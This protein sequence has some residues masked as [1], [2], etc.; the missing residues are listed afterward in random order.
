[1]ISHDYTRNKNVYSDFWS[2]RWRRYW[3]YSNQTKLR[4]FRKLMKNYGLKKRENQFIV[5]VGFGLGAMLFIFP[6]STKIAGLEL[7]ETAVTQAAAAADDKGY[8][9]HDFR[10]YRPDMEYPESWRGKCDLAISS[11][12]LEHI[13][14]PLP[15]LKAMVQLLK[16]N[17]HVC[18]VVPVNESPGDDFNHFHYFSEASFT[19]LVKSAGLEVVFCQSCDRTMRL[20]LPLS[21]YR[22]RNP[23]SA[24]AHGVS[25]FVNAV[26][27]PM[28][29]WVLDALDTGLGIIGVK[30]TQCFILA[31]RCI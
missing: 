18:L 28:P 30:N 9:A 11:H 2:S 12:V 8:C 1:M 14:D 25:I 5:D 3:T 15:T 6:K 21:R 29:S 20:F 17:G 16:L 10:V 23:G 24:W 7:S 22:Q 19:N 26:L 31:K 4:R 13:A 27:A